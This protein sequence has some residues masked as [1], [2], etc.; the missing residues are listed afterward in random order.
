MPLTRCPEVD[1]P[2]H[3][4]TSVST[5]DGQ[6][7]AGD[8]RMNGSATRPQL[9]RRTRR[10]TSEINFTRS[11]LK[12]VGQGTVCRL[13]HSVSHHLPKRLRLDFIYC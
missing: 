11:K 12:I 10:K 9:C 8:D 6:R 3:I 5:C 13:V 1:R 2:F 7:G 4:P